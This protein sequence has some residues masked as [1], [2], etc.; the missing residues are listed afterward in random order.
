VPKKGSFN[1]FAHVDA[2]VHLKTSDDSTGILAIQKFG[3]MYLNPSNGGRLVPVQNY[4]NFSF[5]SL[6]KLLR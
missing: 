2:C 4:R 6:A 1:K 5:Y 3:Y